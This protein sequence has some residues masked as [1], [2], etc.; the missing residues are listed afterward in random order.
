VPIY[1]TKREPAANDRAREAKIETKRVGKRA[2]QACVR[3]E[4][5]QMPETETHNGDGKT[6]QKS[7]GY[8]T[9]EFLINLLTLIVLTVTLVFVAKYAHEARRQTRF[10]NG[11]V[12]EQIE[13]VKQQAMTNRPVII[14]DGISAQGKNEKGTPDKVAVVTINFGKTTAEIVTTIGHIFVVNNGDS[15]PFDPE[16]NEKGA[17]P[18]GQ[19]V[20]ALVPFVPPQPITVTVPPK[21]RGDKPATAI[22]Y[23]QAIGTVAWIWDLAQGQDL[24]DL[25]GKTVFIT[26]CIYYKGLDHKRYFSDVCVSWGG[27]D[28][29]PTCTDL[30]RNFIH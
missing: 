10:L 3:G 4:G 14:A 26:G 24:T 13:A 18:K 20:T 6:P 1:R 11:S 17:W 15:A 2:N 5:F 8:S 22:I 16:C 12:K 19:K 25:S 27:G 7:E 29:F 21:K 23:P 9:P 30:A 28:Y